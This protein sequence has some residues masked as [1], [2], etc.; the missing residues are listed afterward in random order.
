MA[1]STAFPTWV[2]LITLALLIAMMLWTNQR[3]AA[4]Q[5]VELRANEAELRAAYAETVLTVQTSAQ[6][7]T[8]T[9]FA[10]AQSPEAAV[11]R[12]LRVLLAAEREPT[13]QRLRAVN[14]AFGPAALSVIRPQIEHLLSGGLHLSPQS[15]YELTVLGTT[16][17]SP[18]QAEV[19]TRER[20][21]YDERGPDDRVARCLVESSEQTYTLQRAGPD[22]QVVDLQVDSSTRADCASP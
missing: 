15:S 17:R 14:E 4:F 11:D 2:A 5:A 16:L 13:E 6:V 8:A 12:S 20:W 9:A 10:Y 7:A 1:L 22:W 19:R 21:T 18:E 3:E